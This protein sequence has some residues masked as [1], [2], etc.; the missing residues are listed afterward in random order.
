[1]YPL[2][3]TVNCLLKSFFGPLQI[4]YLHL[5]VSLVVFV[6]YFLSDSTAYKYS[7]YAS[8]R[9]HVMSTFRFEEA[10]SFAVAG[11]AAVQKTSNREIKT[12]N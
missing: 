10:E 8:T 12:L 4:L 1:M 6:T 2:Q 5:L 3:S 9:I 11:V 7:F